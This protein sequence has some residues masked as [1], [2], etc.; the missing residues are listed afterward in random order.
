MKQSLLEML[1]RKLEVLFKSYTDRIV[2]VEE[3][4]SR[5][6]KKCERLPDNTALKSSQCIS[7]PISRPSNVIS[8]SSGF[9]PQPG[10]S[11]CDHMCR[12]DLLDDPDIERGCLILIF[13]LLRDSNTE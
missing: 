13:I 11:C 3:S 12:R 1:D 4:I 6:E 8:T 2:S 9:Q 5:I 7:K 10:T